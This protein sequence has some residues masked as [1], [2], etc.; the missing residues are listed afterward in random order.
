MAPGCPGCG[1]DEVLAKLRERFGQIRGLVPQYDLLERG[2][3]GLSDMLMG[4]SEI[5]PR[6]WQT[7]TFLVRLPADPLRAAMMVEAVRARRGRAPY[8]FRLAPNPNESTDF[9]VVDLE[10]IR[11]EAQSFM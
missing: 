7:A 10:V 2:V 1:D 6:D 9:T 3:R 4:L 11:M 5:T 8:V